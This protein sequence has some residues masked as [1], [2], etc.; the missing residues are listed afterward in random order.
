MTAA[1]RWRERRALDRGALVEGDVL[2]VLAQPHQ[3]IAE[4]GAEPLGHEVEPDQRPAEPEGENRGDDDV[5]VDQEHHRPRHLDAEQHQRPR[6]R[7]QDAGEGDQRDHRIGR[8]DG[9]LA[10][11]GDE[12]GD[13]DLDAL[14][15][16]VDR[17]GD[18][19]AAV[20]GVPAEPVGGELV[21]EPDAPADVERL[22]DVE[23]DQRARH[24]HRRQHAEHAE[25][26]PERL[27]VE[28]LQRAVEAVVPVREQHVHAHREHRQEQD[29]RQHGE[30]PPAAPRRQVRPGDAQELASPAGG[31]GERPGHGE[32]AGG[33]ERERLGQPD[34][35][36]GEFLIPVQARDPF[37]GWRPHRRVP[38]PANACPAAASAGDR[39]GRSRP[40]LVQV[41]IEDGRRTWDNAAPVRPTAHRGGK[42]PLV[43]LPAAGG[44]A[45]SRPHPPTPRGDPRM[46]DARTHFTRRRFNL[47]ALAAC[48]APWPPCSRS[49]PGRPSRSASSSAIRRAAS[50]T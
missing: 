13:V 50:P 17:L 46:T 3:R 4:V 8:A 49:R 32:E 31:A 36:G 43:S 23:G 44:A 33:G 25:Q 15:G 2:G 37:G 12:G 18:E 6:Q 42:L 47:A 26:E 45:A 40:A 29:Q 14:V 19:A 28:R 35:A 16:V 5:D 7:P 22:R 21:G 20:V 34:E 41:S 27:A 24:M 38:E 48:A 9:Q 10:R 11:R 1:K 30:R 39:H